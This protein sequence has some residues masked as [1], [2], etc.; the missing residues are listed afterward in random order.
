MTSLLRQLSR[1]RTPQT[2]VHREKK[3]SVSFLFDFVESKSIDFDT[4]FTIASEGL[5]TLIQLDASISRFKDNLFNESSKSLDRALL[6]PQSNEEINEQIESYLFSVVSNYFLLNSTHKTI[7]WL[8]Q[9]YGVNDQNVDALLASALPY[10]ETRLFARLLQTCSAPKEETSH[11]FWLKSVQT[12]GC[13]L[14]K[15]TLIMHCISVPS[16]LHFICDHF[17]KC[18]SID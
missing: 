3:G 15:S 1:L 11:W 9:K 16:F 13:P 10:H 18:L 12:N 17:T 8:I 14:P 7:E 6:S 4:Y 5:Q 2:S